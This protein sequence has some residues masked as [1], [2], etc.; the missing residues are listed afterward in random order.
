MWL[1]NI[2][3]V[4][5]PHS[6]HAVI[7]FVIAHCRNS[8]NGIVSIVIGLRARYPRFEYDRAKGF[9]T[10]GPALGPTQPP[11]AIGGSYPGG[12]AVGEWG[13]HSPPSSAEVKNEWRYT[14]SPLV[15]LHGMYRRNFTF[16]NTLRRSQC[17]CHQIA[18]GV[19]LLEARDFNFE[20]CWGDGCVP[21]LCCTFLYWSLRPVCVPR[22]NFWNS[23]KNTLHKWKNRD[24]GLLRTC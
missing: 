23:M 1:L 7:V 21:T 24:W 10:F 11:K 5:Y 6:I 12:K 14:L 4:F 20:F 13:Y 19:G 9:K 17:W 18:Y 2:Q 16:L 22:L 3:G 15:C 8:R